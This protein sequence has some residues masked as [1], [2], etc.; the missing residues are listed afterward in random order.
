MSVYVP[1]N[2]SGS[3]VSTIDSPLVATRR[4]LND[5]YVGTQVAF[6]CTGVTFDGTMKHCFLGNRQAKTWDIAYNN[7][8][9]EKILLVEFKKKTVCKRR[10]V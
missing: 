2:N 7:G 5:K 10:N 3:P 6:L 9:E 8:D 4:T 1:E